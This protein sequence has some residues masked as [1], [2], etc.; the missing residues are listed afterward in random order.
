[1]SSS[2][3]GIYHIFCSCFDV[4]CDNISYRYITC[5]LFIFD[6]SQRDLDEMSKTG[7]YS[8]FKDK[9]GGKKKGRGDRK[10]GPKHQKKSAKQR[11]EEAVQLE[12]ELSQRRVEEM[13]EEESIELKDEM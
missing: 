1:M 9:F 13:E 6:I 7:D 10:K 4:S 12:N 3:T 11:R 2:H 8:K 5:F